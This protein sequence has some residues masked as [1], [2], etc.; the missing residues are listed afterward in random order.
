MALFAASEFMALIRSTNWTD[1]SVD[2]VKIGLSAGRKKVVSRR[3]IRLF[4]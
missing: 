4:A 2:G 3:L 1:P